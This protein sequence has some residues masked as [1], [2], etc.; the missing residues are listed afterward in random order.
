MAFH[1]FFPRQAKC[2]YICLQHWAMP[3]CLPAPKLPRSHCHFT[4]SRMAAVRNSLV[5]G[6]RLKLI[7]IEKC[8]QT[9]SVYSSLAFSLPERD[10]PLC[11]ARGG[12]R[13]QAVPPARSSS[14]A[15]RTHLLRGKSHLSLT[16]SL[17]P[18]CSKQA[19]SPLRQAPAHPCYLRPSTPTCPGCL[20]SWKTPHRLTHSHMQAAD[21]Q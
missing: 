17:A 15:I 6:Y 4:C 19:G 20:L 8:L 3:C 10:I 14:P 5:T 16:L 1:A 13:N 7:S 11:P 2:E 18:S 12:R 9:S 21:G